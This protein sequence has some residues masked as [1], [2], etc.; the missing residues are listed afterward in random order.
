FEGVLDADRDPL[1]AELE[2]PRVDPAGSVAQHSADGAGEQPAQVLVGDCSE[3]AD[4]LDSALFSRSSAFGPTPG[5]RRTASGARNAASRQGGM[6]TR[7]P[8][9]RASLATLATTL[10]G[11]TPSEHVRLVAA[12]RAVCTA[13][14]TTRAARK[15]RATSPTSRY[16]SSMPVFSTGRTTPR[17]VSHTPLECSR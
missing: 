17:T 16:P 8:G 7:P 15:S 1:R 6:T 13:S 10:H 4:R 2:L 12:R 11:A 5:S 3:V 9:L 14:A